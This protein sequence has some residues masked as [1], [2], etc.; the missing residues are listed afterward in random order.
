MM[1][2]QYSQD[3]TS[4]QSAHSSPNTVAESRQQPIHSSC[5]IGS[6]RLRTLVEVAETPLTSIFIP[7]LSTERMLSWKNTTYPSA[8]EAKKAYFHSWLL[9]AR[10]TNSV[11]QTAKSEKKIKMTRFCVSSNSGKRSLEKIRK[12]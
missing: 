6:M 3:S 11:M 4:F 9:T 2:W 7:F 10:N 12:S 1:D 8:A 5:V